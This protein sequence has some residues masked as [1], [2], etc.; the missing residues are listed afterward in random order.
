MDL[1]IVY[2]SSGQGT[3]DGGQARRSTV[4]SLDLLQQRHRMR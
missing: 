3:A 4:D 1:L 2:S